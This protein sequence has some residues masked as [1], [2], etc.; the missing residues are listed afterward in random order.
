MCTACAAP[1][2]WL[3]AVDEA[4]SAL[5]AKNERVVQEALDKLLDQN[6]SGCAIIIAHRLTT[7]RNCDLIVVMHEGRKV[8]E[9]THDELIA[10]EIKKKK[11]TNDEGKVRADAD[12]ASLSLKA[13]RGTQPLLKSGGLVVAK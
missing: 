3:C 6:K 9:G 5:D 4:T 8:E 10:V 11:V 7:I 13:L 12:K 1:C 2:C